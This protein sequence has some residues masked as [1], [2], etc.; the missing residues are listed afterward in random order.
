MSVL[1]ESLQLEKD[2]YS[3]TSIFEEMIPWIHTTN[4]RYTQQYQ[5]IALNAKCLRNNKKMEGCGED[6]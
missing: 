4:S 6:H 2:R 1:I 3:K 5:V